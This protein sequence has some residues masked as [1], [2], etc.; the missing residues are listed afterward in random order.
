VTA[1]PLSSTGSNGS[2]NP[3]D[4]TGSRRPRDPV[5]P[6]EATQ[7]V[8]IPLYAPPETEGVFSSTVEL[9]ALP[10]VPE[11]SLPDRPEAGWR[12]RIPWDFLAGAAAWIVA[13]ALLGASAALSWWLITPQLGKPYVYDE[14][15]FA[16]AAHA[17]AETGIPLSNV[18]HMQTETPGDFSKR[19]NWA[20]WHP[21]LYVFTLG[22]AFREWGETEQTARLVGVACNALAA[23][24][25]FAAGTIAL[26]G[27]TRAAP[28]Y[29]AAG[30]AVYVTNPFVI[31]S[32]LLLDIDGTVL[33][34]SVALLLLLYTG[35][36]RLP[37]PL[38]SR[39]TWLLMRAAAF[40]FGLSLWAKMTT[41]WALPVAAALYRVF[42]TRPWRPLRL[43]IELP[44]IPAAGAALFVST[45]WLTCT[46]TG[47]PFLLPF[48]ILDHEL[49]DAAG[50]TSSWREN[51]RLLLDL[52]SYVALWVSPYLIFLFVWAGLARLTDLL[53]GPVRAGARRILRRPVAG[54]PWGA[55]SVDFALIGGA[56]IGAA[57]LIKLAASFPK[58]H[59]TMMPF[60]AVGIAYLLFRYVKRVT[61]W[62]P[63]VYGVV[64][65]GMAG[66]FVSFVA[67]KYV[68]FAG[69]DFVFPLLVWPAALGFAFLI[70]C[71]ALGRHNLP[72]QLTILGLLLTT[73]WS[74]GVNQ[75][76]QRADYSTAYNY[77]SFGQLNTAR[78]LDAI[79][80]S[81][82][83]FIASRDVAY[84]TRGQ[85]YV[86]QDTFWEHLA[87]LEQAGIST[88]DGRIAGYNR[89]DIAALF[90]WDP[91]L[92]RRAH[93]YLD[94]LYEVDF[95]EGPF[96]IFVR[97]SP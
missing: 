88:F 84:Y 85:L 10:E 61:W 54:E 80:A 34:V 14:A 27:R 96:L 18:G 46:L 47:M 57:Y 97:T 13:L 40:A 41:A 51:P 29:A 71:A 64:V 22:Y 25:A 31:Q 75:A 56:A 7:P 76:H 42:A 9:D 19:F 78:R 43:F 48:Q 58:Y 26:W 91:E 5:D 90:L 23:L 83:P 81:G 17:V 65:A 8:T 24:F 69:Y 33:V 70:L 11:T 68:L 95:Q 77:G 86:D 93:A 28:L 72:R 6:D 62:E 45:W 37:T 92:G 73:A 35:L 39:W 38:R 20:L 59:I 60:W 50:S 49:R 44:L 66:Y 15:A 63:F 87:R 2:T 82:Q 94:D 36:F 4:V 53:T 12:R 52:V 67:D 74:W 1:P 55:W 3:P 32:A 21:P 89:V 16:F 30:T 79:V